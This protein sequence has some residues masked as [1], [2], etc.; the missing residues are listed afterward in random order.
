M[1]GLVEGSCLGLF[2]RFRG[3]WDRVPIMVVT[4]ELGEHGLPL[5]IV[6]VLVRCRKLASSVVC[7]YLHC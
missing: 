4:I 3:R 5:N 6:P 7:A 2:V 1:T